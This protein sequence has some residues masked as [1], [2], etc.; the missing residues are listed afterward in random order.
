[1]FDPAAVVYKRWLDLSANIKAFTVFIALVPHEQYP[2]SPQSFVTLECDIYAT[3]HA[4]Y[5][6]RKAFSQNLC[7]YCENQSKKLFWSFSW[8]CSKRFSEISI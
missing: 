8:D 3:V 2:M 7:V 6:W 1:M 5:K 4:K